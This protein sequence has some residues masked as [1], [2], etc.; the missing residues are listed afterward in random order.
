MN[1]NPTNKQHILLMETISLSYYSVTMPT[2]LHLLITSNLTCSSSLT[3]LCT[4]PFFTPSSSLPHFTFPTFL[5][6]FIYFF[7]I[8][9]F[10]ILFYISWFFCSLTFTVICGKDWFNKDCWF[11][12]KPLPSHFWKE[13]NNVFWTELPLGWHSIP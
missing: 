9:F 13:T 6:F 1:K 11:S 2:F 7:F 10:Y 4:S 12:L 8:Y 5:Y 3:M